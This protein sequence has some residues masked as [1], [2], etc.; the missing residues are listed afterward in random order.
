MSTPDLR[1][2]GREDAAAFVALFDA[3]FGPG[4]HA[5]TAERVREA[6]PHAPELS[7]GAW[8]GGRLVGAV[9]QHR[10]RIGE[11]RGTFLGPFAVARDRRGEGIGP[12]LI[13][14]AVDLSQAAGVDFVLLVGPQSYFAPLGFGQAEPLIMP[15]AVDPTR[16]L[17]RVLTGSAPA[18]R[19]E[20]DV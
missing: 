10:V 11:S 2:E 8:E 16:L 17:V 19:V 5:K 6:A 9:R 20:A 14:A 12:R 13:A 4:R 7:V 18:G 3:A 1:F 15:G